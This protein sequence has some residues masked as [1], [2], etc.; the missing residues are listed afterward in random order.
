MSNFTYRLYH[1]TAPASFPGLPL[2]DNSLVFRNGLLQLPN[3]DY[4]LTG[5][6]FK[7]LPAR[8]ATGDVI[9]VAS[10]PTAAAPPSYTPLAIGTAALPFATTGVSYS[11]TVAASGG[12]PPYAWSASG[13]PDGFT[14]DSAT[15]VIS[16]TATAPGTA[17]VNLVVTDSAA[18][19]DICTVTLPLQV[20]ASFL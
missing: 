18:A 15:G 6:T 13:L 9:A 2:P 16:G 1:V 12:I 17:T 7:M 8:L 20:V 19:L 11:T 3:V 4:S 14:L 5:T 10:M